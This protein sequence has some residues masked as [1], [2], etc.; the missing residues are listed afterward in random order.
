[1]GSALPPASG[2]PVPPAEQFS[3]A[4]VNYVI[5][6]IFLVSAI[7][8]CDRTI[9]AVLVDDIRA[10]LALDDR[11]MG[12]V[13]G[14]AF[15]ITY[16]LA[17]VPIAR[18][19]D[20]SRRAPIVAGALFAWSLMTAASGLVQSYVQLLLARMGVGL[21]EAGGSPPCHSLLMDYVPA[22]RRARAM[23]WLPIGA[24]VGVGGGMYYGGWASEQFGWRLALISVGIP[25]CLLALLFLGT[26]KEP[27]RR[28][29]DASAATLA[30]GTLSEVLL[31]LL[32][33][34]A[35]R[36]LM[37]ASS[38]AMTAG[39]ART[40]WEPTLL[41]RVYGLGPADAGAIYLLIS[42]LPSALGTWLGA[43]IADRLSVR[44]RR[45][46]A[47]VPAI[48]SAAL[49]PFAVGFYLLPVE[50]QFAG[51]RVGFV[52]AVMASLLS[53]AWSAPV[54]ATAQ[55]LVPPQAR[56][57]S[58]AVWTTVAGFVGGSLGPLLI[59]DLNM[60]LQP[61]AGAESVR[62]SL[63][64]VAMVPVLAAIAF[65]R[66]ARWMPSAVCV[67]PAEETP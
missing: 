55:V 59:G 36:W 21:G 38:I 30:T 16:L 4:Y 61:V 6:L 34:P 50:L 15:S 41:R 43:L 20:R 9:V 51:V 8:V 19:A 65:A 40:F 45:W 66:L 10:E 25:G 29:A 18:L 28:I 57:V 22:E 26:V 63:A 44:D 54:M 53:G 35:F 60:R 3:S 24:L 64:L 56:A 58:A 32:R 47:W 7:N 37:V 67:R 33:N 27:P 17:S 39:M 42:T 2:P 13:M 11:Q 23:S 1:M 52:M 48:G 49:V 31:G 62:W 5:A 46:Y 12:V 14:F